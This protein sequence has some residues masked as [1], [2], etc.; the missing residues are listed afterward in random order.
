MNKDPDRRLGTKGGTAEIFA[1]PWLNGAS[2]IDVLAKK[3]TPPLKPN[4]LN[5]NFDD[6]E[7]R[8]GEHHDM[9]VLRKEKEEGDLREPKFGDFYY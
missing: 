1:H 6:S 8:A 7:Y 5:Y 4:L 9:E 3:L 2:I